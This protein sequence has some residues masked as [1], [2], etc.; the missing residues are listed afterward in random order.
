MNVEGCSTLNYELSWS[1][2]HRE[3]GISDVTWRVAMIENRNDW[4]LSGPGSE[5]DLR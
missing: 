5:E 3:I 1:L 4:A 2:L